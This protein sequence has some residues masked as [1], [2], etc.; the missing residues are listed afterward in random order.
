MV[1]CTSFFGSGWS[2]AVARCSTNAGSSTRDALR[3]CAEG[4]G[5]G[6]R[7]PMHRNWNFPLKAAEND[8][9]IDVV[10]SLEMNGVGVAALKSCTMQTGALPQAF[11]NLTWQEVTAPPVVIAPA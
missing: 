2:Q 11:A 5:L 6:H 7:T 10:S 8:T 9:V 3:S 4:N 1:V